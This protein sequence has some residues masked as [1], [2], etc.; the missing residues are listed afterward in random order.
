MSGAEH[1][2]MRLARALLRALLRA[3]RRF[4]D[5]WLGDFVG[6]LILFA[7]GYLL[8]MIAYGLGFY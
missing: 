5:S 6:G 4:E 1:R 3:L 7:T 8:M 2:A